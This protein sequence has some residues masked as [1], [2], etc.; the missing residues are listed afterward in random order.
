M[1][2]ETQKDPGYGRRRIHRLPSCGQAYQ[3][4]KIIPA[5]SEAVYGNL[6]PP[7]YYFDNVFTS[8]ASASL[9]AA[10]FRKPIK[11]Q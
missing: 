9:L 8:S 4:L 1:Q 10:A 2:R 3:R 6:L 7:P 11:V 5:R